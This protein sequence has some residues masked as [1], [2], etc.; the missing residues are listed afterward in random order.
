MKK[1]TKNKSGLFWAKVAFRAR[2][3]MSCPIRRSMFWAAL[4]GADPN[5]CE[6][7]TQVDAAKKYFTSDQGKSND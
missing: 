4:N 3:R 1:Q 6:K 2:Q 5:E 7:Y